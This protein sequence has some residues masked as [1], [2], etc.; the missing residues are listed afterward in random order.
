[1]TALPQDSSSGRPPLIEALLHEDAYPHPATDLRLYETHISWVVVAG[2]YAY[3]LKK[4]LDLGFLDFSTLERRRAACEDEVRL[5]RRLSPSVYLGV[6]WVVERDGGYQ[7]G[8][9]GRAVEPATWMRRLPKLLARGEVDARLVGRIARRVARFHSRAATGPGVDNY[10]SPDALRSNWDENFA[11]TAAFVSRTISADAYSA[12]RAYVERFLSS[13]R[14][15]L[16]R[17]VAAGRVRDGH[18]DLHAASICLE[19]RRLHIFDCL[20][21]APR[22]RCADVA[23]EVAFLAMDLDHA[24]RTDLAQAFVDAYVRAS[25]D[26]ELLLVLDFYRCSRAYVRGKVLSLRLD[27]PGLPPGQREPLVADARRYFEQARAYAGQ[28]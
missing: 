2:P 14:P 4:P 18:G 21:F 13:Q 25:G 7:M 1:M 20:E 17:R 9:P 19:G 11:Q 27:Q 15:L 3:K 5:N 6:A 24:G 12:L 23:A 28:P 8:G 22:F 16:E 10:G 26:G